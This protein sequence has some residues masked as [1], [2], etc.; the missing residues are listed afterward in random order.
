[1]WI[2][3]DAPIIDLVKNGRVLSFT[4]QNGLPN[5]PIDKIISDRDGVLWIATRQGLS[6]LQ[7]THC[8]L[9]GLDWGYTGGVPSA[10]L[11]DKDGT[12]WVMSHDGRLFFLE[13]GAKKFGINISGSDVGGYDSFLSQAPD[14]VVWESSHAGLRRVLRGSKDQRG[15]ST[16]VLDPRIGPTSFLFDRDGT[17]WIEL[18]DGSIAFCI[19]KDLSHGARSQTDRFL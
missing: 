17:H 16:S 10:I 2:G 1:L 5:A 8:I 18:L 11:S 7:G 12:L 9:I 3:H 4:Q 13:H 6:R 19:P 15:S 14:G